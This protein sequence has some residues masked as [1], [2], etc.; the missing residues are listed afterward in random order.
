MH[1]RHFRCLNHDVPTEQTVN[2]KTNTL[3]LMMISA[4]EEDGNEQYIQSLRHYHILIQCLTPELISLSHTTSAPEPEPI[5]L[6]HRLFGTALLTLGTVGNC[7]VAFVW[8][9][10]FEC[11]RSDIELKLSACCCRCR[12]HVLEARSVLL[13]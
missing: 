8:G 10:V 3:V 1:T 2:V 6:N 13:L 5:N 11:I 7:L 9:A 12:V 4:Q